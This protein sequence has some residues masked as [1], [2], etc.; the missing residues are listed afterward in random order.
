MI[1][2][3]R[4]DGG[5]NR[6]VV[7]GAP[8]RDARAIE[9]ALSEMARVHRLLDHPMIPKVIELGKHEDVP[10]LELD[11]DAVASAQMLSTWI[12]ESGDRL[13]YGQAD[14]VFTQV[15]EAMQAAHRVIDPRTERS[16]CLGRVS[17]ANLLY[18][19]DGRAWV[20]GFGHNVALALESGADDG[21]NAVYQAPEVALG[22]PATPSSD[23]V[24]VLLAARAHTTLADVAAIAAAVVGGANATRRSVELLKVVRYFETQWV[25]QIPSARPPIEEGLKTSE[26]VR[27]LLG[28][29]L[30]VAGLG[31]RVAALVREHLPVVDLDAS[32]EGR[33]GVLRMARDGSWVA[34]PRGKQR[35]GRAHARM[36]VA[37]VDAHRQR[38]VVDVWRLLD[39]AWPGEEPQA[40][41][42][43]N[44]VYVS[45]TRLRNMGLRDVIERAHGGWRIH[46]RTEVRLG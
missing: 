35:L 12:A 17:L 28:K 1:S 15:R 25:S 24:A 4:A 41:A 37:L 6:L 16:V 29:P 36:M 27:E 39:A 9:V 10:F 40:D 20:V 34:T 38:E 31:R 45:L 2:A 18:A 26:R 3:E 11:C 22:A 13:P 8:R 21:M 30:D 46:P 32:P 44:R 23:Y 42:G 14:A 7:V 33:G 43:A 5:G 19:R